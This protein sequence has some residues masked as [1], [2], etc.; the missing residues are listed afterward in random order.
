MTVF[1]VCKDHIYYFNTDHISCLILG[2]LTS[3][4]PMYLLELSPMRLKGAMGAVFS[5]GFAIGIL[6]AHFLGLSSVL[7]IQY[8]TRQM[9]KIM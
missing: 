1:C 4:A 3:I 8:F 9:L 6:F 2:L 7:G 5:F